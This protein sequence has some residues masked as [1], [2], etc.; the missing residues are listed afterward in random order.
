M[1]IGVPKEIKEEEYRVAITPEGVL[2][3][4]RAG[5]S[6]I[7]EKGAGEGSGFFDDDYIKAGAQVSD[8]TE[9][10][11]KSQLI[12]KVKEPLKKEYDLLQEGQ[13]LF[14]FLHLA[15]NRE[16]INILIQKKIAAFAYET[17]EI[18]RR[19]PLLEPMS[20]IAG[21]MA[22]LVGSFYLQRVYGGRGVLPMGVAGVKPVKVLILGAGNVGINSARVALNLGLD[23]VVLNRGIERLKKLEELFNGKVKTL[24]LNEHN[25]K[26]EISDADI[27]VGAILVPGGRTPIYIRRDMLKLMKKG[28]V[29]VDV[30][31]DQGGCVETIVPTTHR[32]PIYQVDGIIH[33][34]VANMPG[35]YPRTSTI[36]L[37]NAT[38]PYILRLAN[39]GIERA[40]E[41]KEISSALN[42]YKGEI[43]HRQLKNEFK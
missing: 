8:I 6:V 13:A 20:E 24:V 40:A 23:V 5:H 31:V 2:E 37:S 43:V 34:G 36:A 10:Y 9:I 1:I 35:A 7:V 3:L 33:Y 14:T 18:E 28:A 39:M 26:N 41:D 30:S 42:I 17:L 11:K 29:I 22:P 32:E 4:V 25:I 12:V 15:A 38:L 19:F 16:L 27:I 21:R